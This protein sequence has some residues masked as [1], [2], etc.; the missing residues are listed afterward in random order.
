MS[1]AGTDDDGGF[2]KEAERE[3]LRKKYEEDQ[4]K[5]ESTQRMSELLL[6]GA[7][8]TNEHCDRCGNPRF[9][10][11]GDTFCPSC[12]GEAEESE[13]QTGARGAAG[14]ADETEA[15]EQPAPNEPDA[16]TETAASAERTRSPEPET[17]TAERQP[18]PTPEPEPTRTRSPTQ[19]P[20]TTQ[21]P[22]RGTATRT[23]EE[24]D[25][26]ASARASVRATLND[27]A[28][29]AERSND[30]AHTRELLAAT[31][32]AAQ[33]LRELNRLE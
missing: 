31:K 20:N 13:T 14:E 21:Q 17:E 12:E 27:L 4:Q 24:A 11:E 18:K 33:T 9:R 26:L 15:P 10:Y 2:D 29:R 28:A 3:K 19:E 25:D 8:M 32:E 5:R 7:T 6:Q 16:G 30:A 22:E 1:D 23:A